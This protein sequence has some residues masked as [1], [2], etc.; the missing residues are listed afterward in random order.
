MKE[1]KE[2]DRSKEREEEELERKKFH[3]SL[4]A[5]GVVAGTGLS[6]LGGTVLYGGKKADK[7]VKELAEGKRKEAWGSKKIPLDKI[8]PK[9]KVAGGVMLALGIPTL[10]YSAYKHYKYR[11][12]NKDDNKA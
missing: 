8:G 2:I 9:A 6:A 12:E 5:K 1:K 4:A 11:K 3:K 10:G 7:I